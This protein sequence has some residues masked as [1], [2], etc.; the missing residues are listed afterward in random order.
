MSSLISSVP[1]GFGKNFR[2]KNAFSK[3]ET[4]DRLSHPADCP[5]SNWGPCLLYSSLGSVLPP[6]IPF[7]LA[8][9]AVTHHFLKQLSCLLLGM[10]K[11]PSG[12]GQGCDFAHRPCTT[13]IPC[14]LSSLHPRADTQEC[15]LSGSHEIQPNPNT[16]ILLLLV[17]PLLPC[18][19]CRYVCA[20]W[21][22]PA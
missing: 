17:R 13:A 8:A 5:R 6:H 20:V 10:E 18:S 9:F 14:S 3:P 7:S 12:A 22:C 21:Q 19:L 4:T 11:L 2:N 15:L 16:V 1:P